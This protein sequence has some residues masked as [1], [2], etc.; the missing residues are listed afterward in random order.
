M[1]CSSVVRQKSKGDYFNWIEIVNSSLVLSLTFQFKSKLLCLDKFR[2]FVYILKQRI[3]C[4][5]RISIFGAFSVGKKCTL[6]TGK[7]GS[8]ILLSTKSP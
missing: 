2:V 8:L 3:P 6:Y 4:I 5:I 1:L 7:Y